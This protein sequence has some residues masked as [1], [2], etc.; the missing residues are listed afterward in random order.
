MV[1]EMAGCSLMLVLFF[2]RSGLESQFLP[3]QKLKFFFF[4]LKTENSQTP[5]WP[6]VAT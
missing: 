4:L 2:I 3:K 6:G 1:A 5:M